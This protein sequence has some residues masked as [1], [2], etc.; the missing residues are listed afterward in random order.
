MKTIPTLNY[1]AAQLAANTLGLDI[2]SVA[3]QEHSPSS[4]TRMRRASSTPVQAR[5]P[6]SQQPGSS[7]D[8]QHESALGSARRLSKRLSTRFTRDLDDRTSPSPPRRMADRNNKENEYPS[9]A[10]PSN[11]LPVPQKPQPA[12][13]R[14]VY[15]T[16]G[17]DR[18]MLT[19]FG[20]S[21]PGE[22]SIVQTHTTTVHAGRPR[23]LSLATSLLS[24]D[25]WNDD[26]PEPVETLP[27]ASPGQLDHIHGK[28]LAESHENHLN[29][30]S[31]RRSLHA[32]SDD[33]T[34]GTMTA[35]DAAH[36][37]QSHHS[38][39]EDWTH[40]PSPP[41]LASPIEQHQR[42]SPFVPSP[43]RQRSVGS[44]WYG[45][46]SSPETSPVLAKRK[47]P[48]LAARP[49]MPDFM[50]PVVAD[51]AAIPQSPAND[52]KHGM[53]IDT[54]KAILQEHNDQISPLP[55]SL[56][57]GYGSMHSQPP[58]SSSLKLRLPPPTSNYGTSIGDASVRSRPGTTMTTDGNI[59]PGRRRVLRTASGG[60]YSVPVPIMPA[61]SWDDDFGEGGSGGGDPVATTLAVPASIRRS[62][63]SLRSHVWL[64]R[65]F[66]DLV[67]DLKQASHCAHT[68]TL[69]E[70][71]SPSVPADVKDALDE[72]EAIIALADQG[73]TEFEAA[74]SLR[75]IE[76]AVF[77][78]HAQILTRILGPTDT[79]LVDGRIRLD[80]QVLG[81]L[82]EK[83]QALL[84]T[85][86]SYTALD[87]EPRVLAAQK[88]QEAGGPE[89]EGEDE[90]ALWL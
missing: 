51:A 55:G 37:L 82:N 77:L 75:S 86:S 70:A 90:D 8:E 52:R 15:P 78:Q 43:G 13:I 72:A 46:A 53:R 41:Q 21:H 31:S 30:R 10:S 9:T 88:S 76:S 85:L 79:T 33:T 89:L 63:A 57:S 80:G 35:Q 59:I 1:V 49:R 54:A 4:P 73:E 68:R 14:R 28:M 38:S 87:H 36:H 48:P 17:Q 7:L 56:R 12:S 19:P 67:A 47:P 66:A 11:N 58:A 20:M 81:I 26:V 74:D 32:Q 25:S 3:G 64:L 2:A 44:L 84:A 45:N 27:L 50:N 16:A 18:R 61:E 29:K 6:S 39:S 34:Y 69:A 24:C 23:G 42:S 5:R 60:S 65:Q 40:S 83:C 62:Q 22:P 71:T